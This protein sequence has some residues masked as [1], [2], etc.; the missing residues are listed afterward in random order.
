MTTLSPISSLA[1]ETLADIFLFV[2]DLSDRPQGKASL[3]VSWVCHT[4]RR[5]ALLTS[6]LWTKIDFTNP[7]W[8]SEAVMRSGNRLLSIHFSG[9]S[10]KSP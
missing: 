1:F 4:W 5:I 6:D 9:D 7:E 8:M 3:T 10:N 2:R